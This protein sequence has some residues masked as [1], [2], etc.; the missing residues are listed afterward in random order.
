MSLFTNIREQRESTDQTTISHPDVIKHYAIMKNNGA[1]S[2]NK[3]MTEN[4]VYGR[5]YAKL[6]NIDTSGGYDQISCQV[7]ASVCK[8]LS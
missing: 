5:F 7:S 4:W 8:F 2:R 3:H 1:H 6:I